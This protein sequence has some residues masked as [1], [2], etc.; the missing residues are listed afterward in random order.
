MVKEVE[1]LH[2]HPTI[3]RHIA[4]NVTTQP[5]LLLSEIK[6]M[7]KEAMRTRKISAT[8]FL[9]QTLSIQKASL[10]LFLRILQKFFKNN[11]DESTCCLIASGR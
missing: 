5:K 6:G 8:L 10:F 1:K 4:E 2:L 9:I 7:H 11:Q 3:R